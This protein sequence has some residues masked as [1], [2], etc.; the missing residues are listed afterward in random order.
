MSN[1]HDIEEAAALWLARRDA[2]LG[3]RQETEFTAWLACD[4]RHR[5]A[6]LRLAQAWEQSARLSRLR[7]VGDEIDPNLLAP[8][9][10][11]GL[12][13]RRRTSLMLAASLAALTG[14]AAWWMLGPERAHVYRTDIGG[15]SRIVLKDGSAVTLNTDTELRVQ[16]TESR[17]R[18]GLLR[19]EA[20]FQ[21]AHDA[22][23]PF[24]VE[25]AGRIMRAVG[26]AFDVRLRSPDS[27]E[28]VVT[29][30]KVAI[31]G[32]AGPSAATGNE[33]TTV[34]AGESAV[35]T[36]QD[37]AIRRLAGAEASRRL[38]WQQGELSFQGETLA[39]AVDEFNRYNRVKLK[40]DDP[41]IA[42]VSIG[43]NFQAL[44]VESFV[45]ALDRS[46]GI[47][48]TTA[49]DGSVLLRSAA[50]ESH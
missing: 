8:K 42:Q 41:S 34:S 16:F 35:A 23:H 20:Q 5:S 6:Y 1:A 21:V 12:F 48:S 11:R 33:T 44:D 39:Q 27:V 22:R 25:V 29:E 43:G 26:T 19:G 37:V 18:I 36:A 2:G 31:V 49:A 24:D 15:L 17:R 30:G 14:L 40:I 46:F 9:R 3:G 13:G 28:L 47:R 32:Q 45:E 50:P 38:A 10:A 4:S 7:T